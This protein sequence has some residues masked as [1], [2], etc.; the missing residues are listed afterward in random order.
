MALD[1][2]DFKEQQQNNRDETKGAGVAV[3]HD[4]QHVFT[5]AAGA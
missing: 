1:G 3:V 5:V 4:A 2:V